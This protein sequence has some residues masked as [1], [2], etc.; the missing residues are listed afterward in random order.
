MLTKSEVL[1]RSY[2]EVRSAIV[3]MAAV[4]DR[5]DRGEGDSDGR[6]QQLY[7]AIRLLGNSKDAGPD[8][9]ESILNFF[10]DD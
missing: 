4:L 5:H 8:R 9:C 1:D 6:L 10:S 3:E 2:L 7:E